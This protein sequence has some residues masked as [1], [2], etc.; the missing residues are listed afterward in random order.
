MSD[1]T[2]I[3]DLP[4]DPAGGNNNSNVNIQSSEMS[5]QAPTSM[6][7]D[8]MTINQIVSGLQQASSTGATQLPSRDIAMTTN[9]IMQDPHVQPNYIPPPPQ[10]QNQMLDYTQA[11]EGPD[12]IVE[13]YNNNKKY[14][15]SLDDM[16]SEIQTPLLIAAL[17]FLFQLPFFR[18]YLLSYFPVLFSM[19]GNL[20]INGFLFMSALFGILFYLLNKITVNF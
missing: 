9:N 14:S 10:M 20:N 12:D 5:K 19:D 3:L 1:T 16:Y 4:T 8:Q 18:K 6:T 7:L 13:N 17:Y 15:D 2:S 11:N